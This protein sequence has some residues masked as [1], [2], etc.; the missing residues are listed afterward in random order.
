MNGHRNNGTASI[1]TEKTV[2]RW[3]PGFGM[4]ATIETREKSNIAA[5]VVIMRLALAT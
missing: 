5:M 2:V 1:R 4:S 3:W